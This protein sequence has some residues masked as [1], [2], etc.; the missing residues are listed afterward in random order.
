V[1][2]RVVEFLG[3]HGRLEAPTY[4]AYRHLGIGPA[5]VIAMALVLLTIIALMKERQGVAPG[6]NDALVREAASVLRLKPLV[7]V[8]IIAMLH[9]G[10]LFIIE[11]VEQLAACGSLTNGF[12]WLGGALPIALSIHLAVA[13]VAASILLGVS[14][15]LVRTCG[16]LLAFVGAMVVWLRAFLHRDLSRLLIWRPHRVLSVAPRSARRLGLRAPPTQ[17]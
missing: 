4:G 5:I 14:K 15:D 16:R 2:H 9:L 3:E 1:G 10:F 12:D 13:C 6:R 7:L 11:S 8:G 17:S